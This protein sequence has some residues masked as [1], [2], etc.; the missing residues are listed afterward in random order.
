MRSYI[1]L[2]NF[3]IK[4]LQLELMNLSNKST[5]DLQR[6]EFQSQISENHF[7]LVAGGQFQ[8]GMH[9]IPSVCLY[10]YLT[11]AK[12]IN[13]QFLILAGGC[14]VNLPDH[15]PAIYTSHRIRRFGT[16]TSITNFL[17]F[18]KKFWVKRHTSIFIK[19][20][21]GRK[22]HQ[23]SFCWDYFSK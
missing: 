17:S 19:S 10:V 18:K 12:W 21:F 20:A 15:S 2:V 11:T 7:R 5:G 23:C 1:Q 13:D 22:F 8:V 16:Q 4:Y 3:Q 14:C 9:L 6:V